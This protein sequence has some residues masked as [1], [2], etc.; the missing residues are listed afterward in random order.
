MHQA[1]ALM[2]C[3]APNKREFLLINGKPPSKLWVWS[4]ALADAGRGKSLLPAL[5]NPLTNPSLNAYS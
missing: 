1:K 5:D 2:V 4:P 3:P